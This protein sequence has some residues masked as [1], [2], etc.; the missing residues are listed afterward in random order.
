MPRGDNS[1]YTDKQEKRR[2]GRGKTPGNLTGMSP[3]REPI[4]GAARL[5]RRARKADHNGD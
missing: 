5:K 2:R 4:A 1:K 3:R